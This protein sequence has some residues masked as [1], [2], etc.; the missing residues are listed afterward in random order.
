MKK[1][2]ITHYSDVKDTTEP[3]MI[4]W[5]NIDFLIKEV[6]TDKVLIQRARSLPQFGG[7][8]VV[9]AYLINFQRIIDS[10]SSNGNEFFESIPHETRWGIAM[11]LSR[12]GVVPL[13]IVSNENIGVK[14]EI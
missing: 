13:E 14:N 12:G 2:K 4:D 8:M 9:V 3:H 11:C 1:T 6:Q 10:L 5:D 7:L